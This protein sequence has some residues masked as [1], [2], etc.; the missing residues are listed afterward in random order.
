M[1][2]HALTAIEI[3]ALAL[4]TLTVP[5]ERGEPVSH[6]GGKCPSK[7]ETRRRAALQWFI[8]TLAIAG[9]GMAGVHVDVWLDQ[10]IVS[11]DQTGRND[12]PDWKREATK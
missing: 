9:A 4:S 5:V 1:N 2:K 10:S 3:E 6:D 8:D 12:R 11:D 7:P